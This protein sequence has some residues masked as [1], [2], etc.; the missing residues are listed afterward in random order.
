MT[1]KLTW[2][3]RSRLRFRAFG[4]KGSHLACQRLKEAV[5]EI[6]KV[7]RTDPV[8]A[9]DGVVSQKEIAALDL[10]HTAYVYTQN[11]VS[12]MSERLAALKEIAPIADTRR[13]SPRARKE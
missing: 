5:T 2:A 4:W 7:A 8:T 1:A 12:V 9:G 11:H 6:K 10:A 13:L 3:F